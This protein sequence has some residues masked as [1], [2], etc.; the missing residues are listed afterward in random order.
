ML[1]LCAA[2]YRSALSQR[3]RAQR[4]RELTTGAPAR[5]RH[6]G[7]EQRYQPH[8]E[9]G[10]DENRRQAERGYLHTQ[11]ISASPSTLTTLS[12][13]IFAEPQ[14]L[15]Q[16]VRRGELARQQRQRDKRRE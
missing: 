15:A 11:V 16:A 4:A 7:R 1:D 14:R 8:H 9:P 5:Q 6:E 3:A 2:R 13:L 12:I 10:G